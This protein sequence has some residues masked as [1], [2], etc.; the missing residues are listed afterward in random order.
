MNLDIYPHDLVWGVKLDCLPSH[1]PRW[2]HTVVMQ[3]IPVVV[4]R[5]VLCVDGIP[6]GVRGNNRAE[7]FGMYLPLTA[8]TRVVHPEELRIHHVH[9]H[10][11]LMMR[12]H[13]QLLA[14]EN[15]LERLGW[16]WGYTGSFG[17]ELATGLSTTHSD[18]DIDLLLRIPAF[19]DRQ[20]ASELWQDLSTLKLPIDVQ[21]QTPLGGVALAE[22]ANNAT[23]RKVL[24][25]QNH[26]AI[27]THNPWQI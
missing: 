17:F 25:K 22:W 7:R 16:V 27:L 20:A 23:H 2:V 26:Q 1:A 15:L 21:I 4:R 12:W 19:M 10:S 6:V 8:I 24:L 14:L 9:A 13:T 18:S 5:D 3:N 11:A